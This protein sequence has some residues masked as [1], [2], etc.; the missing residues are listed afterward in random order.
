MVATSSPR[1]RNQ[2]AK[3]LFFFGQRFPKKVRSLR[4]DRSHRAATSRSTTGSLSPTVLQFRDSLPHSPHTWARQHPSL[5][6]A[7]GNRS[8][9]PQLWLNRSNATLGEAALLR[10][11]AERDGRHAARM[12]HQSQAGIPP[13][14]VRVTASPSIA[15]AKK[16]DSVSSTNRKRSRQGSKEI[17]PG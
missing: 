11:G 16:Q 17:S 2:C 8:E 1:W 3:R 12:P 15:L 9:R 4:D 10:C 7:L 6:E 13:L 14:W 5:L